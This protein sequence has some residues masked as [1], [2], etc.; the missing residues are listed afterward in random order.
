MTKNHVERTPYPTNPLL[1]AVWQFTAR[2]LTA[3]ALYHRHPEVLAWCPL[4]PE[5]LLPEL[6]PPALAYPAP[7]EAYMHWLPSSQVKFQDLN[8]LSDLLICDDFWHV[9][10]GYQ[11]VLLLPC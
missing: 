4:E 2:V 9:F 1:N 7:V 11:C 10:C 3:C 5:K 6:V 8:V